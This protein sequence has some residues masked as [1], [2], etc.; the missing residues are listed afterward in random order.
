MSYSRLLI[1]A[2]L[3]VSALTRPTNA[4]GS[5]DQVKVDAGVLQGAV[6]NGVLSFKGIPF[7]APP[8]G[9]LRWKPPQPVAPW[10]GVR[11]ATA[12]G[13]DCMQLPFPGDA[14]PLGTPPAE[15][16]LVRERLAAG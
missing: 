13:S 1:V 7:A 5:S 4:A 8:V 6:D 12:Y 14:A 10:T 2:A 16:C 9:D 11:P 3:V 15:D